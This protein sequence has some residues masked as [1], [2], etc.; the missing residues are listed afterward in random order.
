M[1]YLILLCLLFLPLPP[2]R[3]IILSFFILLIGACRPET[4]VPKPRG[5]FNIALPEKG[6]Q[7]FEQAGFP[8][9]FDYPVYGKINR[10][11]NA[12]PLRPENPYWMN[13]DF[14][15]M[16]ASIYLSYKTIDAAHTFERLLDDAHELSYTAH[17]K[18]AD[19][20]NTPSF[21]NGHGVKGVFYTV[22]GNTA[23]R[24]QF[25]ATDSVKHFLRGALYFN[26]PPNADS[27]QPVN[28]FLKKDMEHLIETLRWK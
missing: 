10:D 6:Y 1:G 13:I 18:K 25:F 26:V 23:T 4:Y 16:G 9:E 2:M 19:Y 8:Y 11:S 12:A 7:H 24:Y 22:G 15:E 21:D 27:L 3:Y 20:I 14:P 5:Y 17:G 28:D